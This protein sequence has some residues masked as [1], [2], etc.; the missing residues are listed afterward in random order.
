M[1]LL[2]A[3]TGEVAKHQGI[4]KRQSLER[5]TVDTWGCLPYGCQALRPGHPPLSQA[6]ELQAP[7]DA[8]AKDLP[9]SGDPH[10]ERKLEGAPPAPQAVFR[11]ALEKGH[12]LLQQTRK[13]K[14][15]LLSWHAPEVEVIGKRKLAKPLEFGVKVTLAVTNKESFIIGCRSLVGNP[16]DGHTLAEALEQAEIL[17]GVAG[18]RCSCARID[19]AN[20]AKQITLKFEFER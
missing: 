4:L 1:E 11:E 5:I 18:K 7:R 19:P 15:K 3:Y 14:N 17:S 13:S 6:G 20:N 9:G 8:P 10:I 16:Y 2:L 12:R